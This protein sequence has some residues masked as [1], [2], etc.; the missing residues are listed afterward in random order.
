MQ[1]TSRLIAALAA[2]ST[3]PAGAFAQRLFDNVRVDYR[4]ASTPSDMVSADFNGDGFQ[5]VAVTL[6][7]SS[8]VLVYLGMADGSLLPPLQTSVVNTPQCLDA[9][10]IDGDTDIDLV[11]GLTGTDAVRALL[12]NGSGTMSL[13]G[14]VATSGPCNDLVLMQV[15]GA[16]GLDI[17][18]T[19][20]GQ[21]DLLLG[22]GTGGFAAAS[23]VAMSTTGLRLRAANLTNDGRP[24]LIGRAFGA[25]PFL[26]AINNGTTFNTPSLALVSATQNAESAGD[27]DG[28]GDDDVILSTGSPNLYRVLRNDGGSFTQTSTIAPLFAPGAT[29]LADMDG[30]GDRDLFALNTIGPEAATYANLGG[31]TFSTT[32]NRFP[33]GNFPG[34]VIATALGSGTTPDFAFTHLHGISTYMGNGTGSVHKAANL[35]VG[36]PF[37]QVELADADGDGDTDMFCGT[38]TGS[39]VILRRNAGGASFGAPEALP[40]IG[41]IIR[42]ALADTNGDGDS[43]VAA[44]DNSGVLRLCTNDGAG[45]FAAGATF[46]LGNLGDVAAL[47]IEADGDRDL[48]VTLSASNQYRVLLNDSAGNYTL[49]P[50]Q[51]LGGQPTSIVAGDIDNDSD[52]DFAVALVASDQVAIMRNNGSGTFAFSTVATLDQPSGIDLA[53]LNGDGLPELVVPHAGDSFTRIYLNGGG[54]AFSLAAAVTTG[55][56]SSQAKAVDLDGDGDRD[57]AVTCSDQGTVSIIGNL[58]P[59]VFAGLPGYEAGL[60]P[61]SLAAGDIDGNGSPDLVLANTAGGTATLLANSTPTVTGVEV[62]GPREITVTFSEPVENQD[63]FTGSYTLSGTAKGTLATNPTSVAVGAANQRI[64]TWATGEMLDGGDATVSVSTFLRDARQNSLAFQTSRTDI[65]GGIGTAPTG[66]FSTAFGNVTQDLAFQVQLDLSEAPPLFF[67]AGNVVVTNGSIVGTIGAGG[68]F[69]FDVIAAGEGPVTLTVPAGAATDQ[70]GNPTAADI[71]ITVTVDATAPVPALS[72]ADFT[73]VGPAPVSIDYAPGESGS[74]IASAT[75]LARLKGEPSFATV[76]AL[77]TTAQAVPFAPATDGVYELAVS[78]TDVAGNASAAPTPLLTVIYNADGGSFAHAIAGTGAYAFPMTNELDVVATLSG[79]PGPGS[80]MTVNRLI[81]AGAPAGLDPARLA[82]EHL[83]IQGVITG[84]QATISWAYD[85]FSTI[86]LGGQIDTVFQVE[87][88]AVVNQW[89]ATVDASTITFGPV[90]S[91]SEW[92]AGA[93]NASAGEWMVLE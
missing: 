52:T 83:S 44:L 55:S 76:G 21:L 26:T 68:S 45:T 74:G 70:A 23:P 38:Q 67:G 84:A 36:A 49:Q 4:T 10:D 8:L 14:S 34:A 25:S 22:N 58:A 47:D 82:D 5:D 66:A 33:Q 1:S 69:T 42:F 85:P 79:V 88:G 73:R 53:D 37:R 30:D 89:P 78:A 64:L 32:P 81:D 15:D 86:G 62:T 87:G 75:L 59:M 28:D 35:D 91:F 50:A 40:S 54:G 51:P 56:N 27:I 6:P 9:G 29:V 93:A 31:G 48:V 16:L 17:V 18:T 65:G 24:D 41:A 61:V 57:V 20:M 39:G 43:D 11:V 92:W 7:S 13:G 46:N 72:T 80:A 90:S 71:A 2:L 3:L 19:G 12:N 77:P 60:V 63:M